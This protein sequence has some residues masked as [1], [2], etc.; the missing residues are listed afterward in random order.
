MQP[1]LIAGRFLSTIRFVPVVLIGAILAVMLLL[2]SVHRPKAQ[3]AFSFEVDGFTAEL[4]Q[5]LQARP[6]SL[7]DIQTFG[8]LAVR[9]ESDADFRPTQAPLALSAADMNLSALRLSRTA[10]WEVRYTPGAMGLVASQPSGNG[11]VAAFSLVAAGP[12]LAPLCPDSAQEEFALADFELRGETA[13]VAI[14]GMAADAT[15]FQDIRPAVMRFSAIETLG[16][17]QVLQ[18]GTIEDGILWVQDSPADGMAVTG[19]DEITLGAITSGQVQQRPSDHP[20]RLR[21]IGEGVAGQIQTHRSDEALDLRPTLF[22]WAAGSAFFRAIG[23]IAALLGGLQIGYFLKE[24][25][26]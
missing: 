23:A 20:A 12:A 14:A 16:D 3:F 13:S 5:D 7:G 15:P 19:I 10:I 11:L 6:F 25:R 1:T 22:D 21:L 9:C 18:R 24:R 17:R 8:D 26:S 2:S 4:A